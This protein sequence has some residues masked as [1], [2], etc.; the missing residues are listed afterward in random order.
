MIYVGSGLL[1]SSGN[2]D[3][4]LIDPGLRVAQRRP[5]HAGDEIGCWPPYSEIP[6]PCRAA[7]LHW[8]AGGRCDPDADIGY[9]FLYFYGLERVVLVDAP[10]YPALRGHVGAVAGP[11]PCTEVRSRSPSACT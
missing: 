2:L 1:A 9:V 10:A 7:Y 6:A 8:L 4:A 5:D 3:P 11:L